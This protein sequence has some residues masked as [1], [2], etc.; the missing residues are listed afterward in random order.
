MTDDPDPNV[1]RGLL[2]M[3][4]RRFSDAE[5]YFRQSLARNPRNAV[6]LQHLA[7][8]QLRQPDSAKVAL[9]TI[10]D[11]I[12]VEPEWSDL[13]ATRS[14]VLIGLNR[15]DDAVTA[16]IKAVELDPFNVYAHSVR[17]AALFHAERYADAENAAR[18]ALSLDPDDDFAAN[19]LAGAMR[20]QGKK[21]EN[22]DQ[23]RG[24]LSRDPENPHTH[25]SA[26]WSALQNDDR[27]KA[28]EHFVEA[29][30]M[31][32]D[33]ESARSGLLETY[34]ARS[35]FYRGYLKYCFWSQ[36]FTHNNRIGILVGIV[37]GIMLAKRL[38][39]AANAY[40]LYLVLGFTYVLL[41]LWSHLASGVGNFFILLDRVARRSLRP[42]EKRD[43][44]FVGGAVGVG[45]A[46]TVAGVFMSSEPATIIG[47]GFIASAIP[48]ACTFTNPSKLGARLFGAIAV[49]IL[50]GS[51]V[52]AAG[53][54]WPGSVPK[55][56][57]S[58]LV[59]LT[60]FLAVASTWLAGVRSLREE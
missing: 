6:A 30:R 10:D 15:R 53:F 4:Q 36:R 19:I 29:L 9:A 34:K 52:S 13:H 48:F 11:A 27:E 47:V 49:F 58:P 25:A 12:G 55:E 33:N 18:F 42:A 14:Q 22:A 50:V 32:P 1:Q 16:A 31:D 20:I 37:V 28:Q 2:L 56:I 54:A 45:I 21:E 57:L 44:L 26:G 46:L 40:W 23:I 43:G 5:A 3:A 59:M 8:C 39:L 51:W 24:M 38:L 17:A 35:P 60:V 41:V 7:Q